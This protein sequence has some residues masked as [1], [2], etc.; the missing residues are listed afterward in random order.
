MS[1]NIFN[2]PENIHYF[3]YAGMSP[4]PW[5]SVAAGE[6]GVLS[7]QTPWKINTKEAFFSIL[8]DLREKFAQLISTN[9][10][11]IALIPSATYGVTS[12][13]HSLKLN[14]EDELLVMSEE[15]PAIY[16]PFERKAREANA[17]IIVAERK[18][19]Q[20]WTEAILNKITHKTKAI[21]VSPCHWTDG[22]T[23]D[24]QAVGEAARRVG[25]LFVVDG[26]QWV[27]AAPFDVN[28][29][30]PDHLIVPTYK[31]MLGPYQFGFHY[32][33]PQWQQQKPLEEYWASRASAQDFTQLTNYTNEYQLG[34]RRFDMS[35]RSNF[36]TV[37]MALKS[38]EIILELG[39]EEIA[40]KILKKIKWI[41][42]FAISNGL[43]V[44]I[45]QDQSPHFI[46][47][48]NLKGWRPALQDRMAQNNIFASQRGRCLRI[49]PHVE[50]TENDINQLFNFLQK[51]ID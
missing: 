43:S 39:V 5:K 47:L 1:E 41:S 18:N 27:G 33:N 50:T 26:C 30:K 49:A 34:A 24:L 40:Q 6:K 28:K 44:P 38:T 10:K 12:A 31:W 7:K 20:N 9:M 13:I 3:N 32:V 4:L 16:Y 17:K 14:S 2:I 11:D 29:I 37:P 46:G 25:A 35:E 21:G 22:A 48:T 8:D 51:E 36:V 23:V 45:G 15:F 19:G 42:E